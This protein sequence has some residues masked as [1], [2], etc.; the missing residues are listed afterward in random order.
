MDYARG[1]GGAYRRALDGRVG[2]VSSKCKQPFGATAASRLCSLAPTPPHTVSGGL[3][4]ANS[5]Q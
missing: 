2:T 1:L 4:A 5:Q 3:G